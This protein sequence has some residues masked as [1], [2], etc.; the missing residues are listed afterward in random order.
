MKYAFYAVAI[1]VAIGAAYF[2][3]ELG[4]QLE[5]Q[6][7]LRTT[8]VNDN[9][10]MTA[11]AEA[12]EA[13]HQKEAEALEAA[14]GARSEVVAS[15][16]ALNS[17]QTQLKRELNE[18]QGQLEEQKVAFEQADA[19]LEEV[20]KILAGLGPE[21]T[22]D[23]LGEKVA[24][25]QDDRKT[26]RAK[27]QQLEQ[28]VADAE[29]KLKSGEAESAR[30]TQRRVDRTARIGRNAMEAVVT[31]VDQD[32]G[33]VIIGAGSNSGFTPQTSLLVRRDGRYIG[34]VRPSAIEPT[35]TIADIVEDTVAPGVRIQPGDRVILAKPQN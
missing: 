6:R 30:L 32:W 9:L 11:S 31:A 13:D 29:E 25:I 10:K 33:F 20:N 34:R 24:E 14:Q 23:N 3:L 15:I 8:V 7:S 12:T 28:L 21:V 16:A 1:L 19:A 2:S 4:A 35:Q 5:E 17:T 22:L 26:R 18:F 27:L